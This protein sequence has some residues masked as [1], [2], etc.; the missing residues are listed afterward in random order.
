MDLDKAHEEKNTE[1][2]PNILERL[3]KLHV[4]FME[5]EIQKSLED[6]KEIIEFTMK[7]GAVTN[8][9]SSKLRPVSRNRPKSKQKK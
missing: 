9:D 2:L 1:E 4:D 8:P 7:R 5:S 3:T 6:S